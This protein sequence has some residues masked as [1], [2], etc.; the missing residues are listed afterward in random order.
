MEKATLFNKSFQTV[1]TTDNG[2]LPTPPSCSYSPML[3][4][5]ITTSDVLNAINKLKDKVVRTPEGIPAYF[6]KR[7]SHNLLLPLSIIFNNILFENFVPVQW[8][9]SLIIPVYK[10]GDKSNPL[11][12]R[13]ISLTSTFS[14]IFESILHEKITNHLAK[15]SLL[16]PD[17]YGFLAN[18]SSCDQ[19]L[20]CIH[21]WLLSVSE[22]LSIS[23]VYTDVAKAF[24]SVSHVKLIYILRKYGISECVCDWLCNFL[25]DRKQYV[26][27]GSSVS[28]SLS[29]NSGIPQGSVIGPLLFLIY[30][31]SLT[32]TVEPLYGV[33]GIKLFADD[34][35]VYDSSS[36]SLQIS[37][38][39]L[40]SWLEDHQL[41]LA[42][43]KMLHFKYFESQITKPSQIHNG[44]CTSSERRIYE[45]PWHISDN[46]KWQNH[47]N[48]IYNK[49]VL[50]SYQ[51]L[52]SFN[53]K[54]IWILKKTFHHLYPS[55]SGV[56]HSRLVPLSGQRY[57]PNR[58][59]PAI[60]YAKSLFKVWCVL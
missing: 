45:R 21:E 48:Y 28:S 32:K 37:L 46:L 6:V 40:I 60:V 25:S 7:I 38:N 50:S 20:I 23:V 17:Q 13:P 14:R 16:S 33:R 2:K 42:P 41:N 51:I 55:L 1:F 31:N 4:F 53:T 52:K 39:K 9:E 29:V 24:D 10:K 22:G 27:V 18:K 59:Y 11:N 3:D 43:K 8:K 56:Q 5:Q 19:L 49:A 26:C 12:Y 35:K 54:N 36:Q 44:Q 47:I 34:A 15:N 57:F 58:I 30:F